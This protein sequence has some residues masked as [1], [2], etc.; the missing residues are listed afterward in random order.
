MRYG[1]SMISADLPQSAALRWACALGWTVILLVVLLQSS[2]QPVIGPPAP[3]G[4]PS[5]ARE[6]VLTLGHVVGFAGLT[7]LWWWALSWRLRLR[8]ALLLAVLVALSIGIFSE[9]AQAAVPDRAAS[10][11]DLVVNIGVTLV[12]A[13][14]IE[15]RAA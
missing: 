7:V 10:W 12:T 1:V 6:L 13:W 11:F 3:P 5:L 4:D 14:A 8:S 9:L 2:S 15:R